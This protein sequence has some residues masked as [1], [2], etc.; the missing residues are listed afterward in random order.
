MLMVNLPYIS[1]L[2]IDFARVIL[3]ST[4]QLTLRSYELLN[5]RKSFFGTLIY[6]KYC[7][8]LHWRATVSYTL[9]CKFRFISGMLLFYS[10]IYFLLMIPKDLSLISLSSPHYH[11]AHMEAQSALPLDTCRSLNYCLF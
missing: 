2:K 7:L 4:F 11:T 9:R 6:R 10:S 3:E 1:H 8:R 5:N